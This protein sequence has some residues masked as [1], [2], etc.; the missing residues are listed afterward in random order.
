MAVLYFFSVTHGGVPALL[1]LSL[2]LAVYLAVIEVR[3]MDS[4]FRFKAWWVSFVFLT[5]FIG[6]LTLRAY[7]FMR[8]RMDGATG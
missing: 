1:G 4:S 8:R 6:Y 2:A 3:P 5:H 7:V